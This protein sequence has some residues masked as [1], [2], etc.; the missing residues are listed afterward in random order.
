MQPV[1]GELRFGNLERYCPILSSSSFG[2]IGMIG[3]I[4]QH[5]NTTLW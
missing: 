5:R 4:K 2:M 1:S 3:M